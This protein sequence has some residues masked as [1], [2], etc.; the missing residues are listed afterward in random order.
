M[1]R[2]T[3]I[4]FFWKFM[5]KKETFMPPLRRRSLKQDRAAVDWSAAM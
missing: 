3:L 1:E 2:V 5:S 4:S